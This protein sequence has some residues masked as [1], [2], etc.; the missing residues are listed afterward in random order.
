MVARA[1]QCEY[2][3]V[4]LGRHMEGGSDL[5]L[6]MMSERNGGSSVWSLKLPLDVGHLETGT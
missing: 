3:V 6:A 4:V 1:W 5:I 2:D